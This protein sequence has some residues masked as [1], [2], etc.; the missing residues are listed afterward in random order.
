MDASARL[1]SH[2]YLLLAGVGEAEDNVLR[3]V[4]KE[5]RPGQTQRLKVEGTILGEARE[6]KAEEGVPGYEVVF[7]HYVAYA[8]TNES[9]DLRDDDAQYEG[10]LFR[11]YTK[12]RFLDYVRRSTIASDDYPGPYVHYGVICLNHIIDVASVE[13]PRIRRLEGI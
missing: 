8:V 7:E 5:A 11:T 1:N 6:I 4:V 12:S 2:K 3:L 13:V 10:R 9:Y